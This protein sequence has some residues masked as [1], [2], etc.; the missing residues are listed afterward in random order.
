MKWRIR[1]F[2]FITKTDYK[3]VMGYFNADAT[4]RYEKNKINFITTD[5]KKAHTQRRLSDQ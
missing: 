4:Q 1:S 2:H 5:R 3:F